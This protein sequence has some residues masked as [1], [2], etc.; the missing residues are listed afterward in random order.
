MAPATPRSRGFAPPLLTVTLLLAA[1]F[2]AGGGCA[3]AAQEAADG[4]VS[5]GEYILR[6]A[7]CV[8][9]HS[10]SKEEEAFLA[11]GP[12]LKTPFGTFYAPNITPDPEHGI[13]AWSEG[14]FRRALR[15]GQAPDGA[16]YYP[17]FPYPAYSGMTDSDVGDLWAY[18]RTV[19]PGPRADRPH[20]LG[21]PFDLRVLNRVWQWLYFAP[22]RFAPDP[23]RDEAWNRG[24]YLV[25]HLGHC[26]ECHSPRGWLGALDPARELAGNPEGPDGKKVPNITPHRE[27][28]IG[29]WSETD[30]AFFFKTGFLPDG[31]VAGGA[32]EDVIRESTSK[33]TDQDRTALAA[34][35]M[36]LP[37]LALE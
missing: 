14:D 25:R 11:G 2:A 6:A 5:R 19:P 13:G 35:L 24:A 9:C 34:Y 7:G 22:R 10:R 18:L 12:A 8:A 37:P 32:M 16:A 27:Y 31:D 30:L 26:A 36:A 21:F 17:A 33:L 29:G 15:H 3:A 23:E 1:A 20:E 4:P 28:G